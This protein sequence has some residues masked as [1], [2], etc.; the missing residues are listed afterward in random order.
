M[1]VEKDGCIDGKKIMRE[2]ENVLIFYMLYFFNICDG[3]YMNGY[4]ELGSE[5]YLACFVGV[6]SL[7]F[8]CRGY[9]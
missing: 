4:I 7:I 6:Y 1:I 9:L 8:I 3:V 5:R 2:E